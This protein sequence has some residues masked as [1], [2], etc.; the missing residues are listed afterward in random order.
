MYFI[1][2]L[3]QLV[4]DE[5]ADEVRLSVGSPP[6][7]ILT[8]ELQT[9]EGPDLRLE[10]VEQM[11]QRLAN[12]RQRRLL[13]DKGHVQFLYALRNKTPF[14]VTAELRDETIR[15]VVS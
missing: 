9:V 8:G 4:K 11:L 1:D 14:L 5:Q 2:D 7:I 6:V 3:L 15:L 10:D 12:T 13:R